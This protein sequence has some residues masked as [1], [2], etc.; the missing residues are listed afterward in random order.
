MIF[1]YK[2]IN[3]AGE[4]QDGL[5]DA[6][7]MDVAIGALQK[8]GIV[9]SSIKPQATRTL[10]ERIPF[11]NRIKTK[12]VVV[13]SR[14][15]A[16][17]FE[18]QVS[19]LRVFKLIGAQVDNPN[20]RRVMHEI[21]DDL[22]EGASISRAL[23]KHKE[24]FSDFY[25][26]MVAAGE[27]SGRLDQTFSFLADY[28]ERQYEVTSKVKH[29]LVYPAFVVATMIGVMVLMLTFV[30]PQMAPV[31]EESGQEL[32]IYTRA[33][34]WISD[35]TTQYGIIAF[36]VLAIGGFFVVR[37]ARGS[38]KASFDQ[39]K[40]DIPYVGDL[41]KKLY[42][43]RIA[44]NMNTMV[45][46]GISMI[47]ALETTANI[48]GNEIY[49]GILY[50]ALQQ[51]RGGK[52]LSLA[53]SQYPEIPSIMVQMV[54][55]G[56]ETGELGNILKTLAKFYQKEVV[57]AVDTIVDLIEPAMIVLLGLGVGSLLAAVLLPVYNLASSI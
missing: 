25:V 31:L 40:L 57:A 7:N 1:T 36:I 49:K 51:V 18:A 8:R 19:A 12:D 37:Y 39:F 10:T 32:P 38:G 53:L 33:V 34:L 21:S 6:V 11:V 54:K 43:S 44:D 41:Y 14:Q 4:S 50:D 17:L 3:Q 28:L 16:T 13:V 46:S 35:F 9:L 24:A 23:A 55:V 2:G 47:R 48:V 26:N 45:L 27:E 52:A 22:Q 15:M 29:A 5:I 42:L 30:I 20:L 56:E